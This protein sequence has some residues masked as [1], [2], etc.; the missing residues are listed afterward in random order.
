[1]LTTLSLVRSA[2]RALRIRSRRLT[3]MG[4]LGPK[5][6]RLSRSIQTQRR[7]SPRSVQLLKP[8]TEL[9]PSLGHPPLAQSLS[10]HQSIRNLSS[11]T[12][13]R[14]FAARRRESLSVS[15]ISSR[16][17]RR[18]SRLRSK[19]R[20]SSRAARLAFLSRVTLKSTSMLPRRP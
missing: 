14:L 9:L 13:S 2:S 3:L 7:S 15:A 4:Q 11:S 12:K 10:S 20:P 18:G 8:I 5:Q 17:S 19:F 6:S 1:M 16:A